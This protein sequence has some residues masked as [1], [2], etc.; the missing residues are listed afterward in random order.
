M[1]EN[2]QSN[3]S[4]MVLAPI[5]TKFVFDAELVTALID[6]L[7][8]RYDNRELL[9][10]S[11]YSR[12]MAAILPYYYPYGLNFTI[13]PE[14]WAEDRVKPDFTVCITE[15]SRNGSVGYGHST[16]V[17]MVECKKRG[18][19]SWWVL[20]KDQLWNQADALK[21]DRGRLWVVAQIDLVICFFHFDVLNH[22]YPDYDTYRNFSPLNLNNF[23]EEDR[24][25]LGIGYLAES[26][27]SDRNV[28]QVI[29]WRL[30]DPA[31]QRYLHDMFDHITRHNP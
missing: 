9:F 19:V 13:A 12:I 16:P 4:V 29:Q 1:R 23:D 25:N 6:D 17:L 21:N 11:D 18:A 15:L 10:E 5:T 30:D 3:L 20:V 28:I 2:T 26:V 22:T 24:R 14:I 31:H 8:R 7:K 27:S